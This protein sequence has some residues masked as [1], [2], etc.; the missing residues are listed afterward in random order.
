MV[1]TDSALLNRV[2]EIFK[3]LTLIPHGSG[4]MDGIAEYVQDFA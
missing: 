1:K 3:E 4:N 2:F